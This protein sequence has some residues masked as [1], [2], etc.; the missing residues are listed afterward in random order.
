MSK[1][2]RFIKER[3]KVVLPGFMASANAFM[4]K[5]GF[6]TLINNAVDWDPKQWNVSPG[7]LLKA[8]V[9][10]TFT[11]V[12]TPLFK[13]GEAFQNIDTE[14]LLGKGVTPE[15]ITD[16]AIGEALE[17]VYLANAGKLLQTLSLTVF[18]KFE[19]T[20]NR[21]HSDTT[22]ISF[23]GDY[24]KDEEEQVITNE[25]QSLLKE[26]E[27]INIT[28]G[29]NKDHRPDCKQ[30]KLGQ[31]SNEAGIILGCYSMDGNTSDVT[32]NKEALELIKDIQ[33]EFQT[34][35]TIYVA[36]CKLMTKKLFLKMTEDNNSILFI[37]RVPDSFDIKLESRIR[38]QAYQEGNWE[39]IGK[40]SNTN[41]ACT[42]EIQAFREDVY[43]IST[44]LIVV[45]SSASLASFEASCKKRKLEIEAAIKELNKKTFACETDARQEWQSFLKRYQKEPYVFSVELEEIKTEKRPRGNPGK[46]P[47]PPTIII[48]WALNIDIELKVDNQ[49]MELLR[50]KAE[51]FVI[52]SNVPESISTPE[53]LLREYK[54]Q[55]VVELNFKT[56]K[57]P[58]LTS[59]VFLKKEERIE[60]MMMLIGVSLMIRA[61][62]LYKLRKGFQE[63]GE[64]PRIG[65]S[66]TVLKT[67]TMGL[68]QYAM[69]SLSIERQ[70]DGNY[71]IYINKKQK[72]RALTFLR[73]LSL[74]I[75][76]LL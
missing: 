70:E 75:S 47:N 50:Q 58:A 45:K 64:H 11:N 2:Y 68:F 40:I 74:D 42:Y 60:A 63:S 31:I 12:R 25:N 18:K 43:G 38:E 33:K 28:Y 7:I 72:Q 16:S 19:L 20:I 1:K 51:S 39:D 6:A 5:I 59:T 61:L 32:W 62:I 53:K 14:H 13:I 69:D 24:E 73:Y 30:M 37:S 46:N 55:I 54:G 27:N 41:K 10:N 44:R 15:K 34:G 65:Y 36:D 8:V 23:F 3:R 35:N 17:R 67:I 29:H 48:K 57:S 9:L 66:G 49:A 71:L 22:S 26:R 52:I 76:D 56:L 4:E 21:L